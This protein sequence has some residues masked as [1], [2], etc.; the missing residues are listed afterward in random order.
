V[1]TD[2]NIVNEVLNSTSMKKKREREKNE[3]SHICHNSSSDRAINNEALMDYMSYC[4]DIFYST[5]PSVTIFL[6]I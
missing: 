5:K 1:T 4:D 6:E 2:K 3:M